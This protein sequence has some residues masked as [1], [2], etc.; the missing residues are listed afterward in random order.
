MDMNIISVQIPDNIAKTFPEKLELMNK[1]KLRHLEL[2]NQELSLEDISSS[3]LICTRNQ[4]IDEGGTVYLYKSSLSVTKR[5]SIRRLFRNAHLLEVSNVQLDFS[6]GS[7]DDVVY[8][9]DVAES[10][11][12]PLLI[13][14]QSDGPFQN[15]TQLEEFLKQHKNR[16]CGVFFNPLEFLRTGLHPFL[17]VFYAGRVKNHVSALRIN[18]GLYMSKEA[19]FPSRGN[20]E[21]KELISAMKVRSF[22]G[23]FSLTPYLPG[24]TSQDLMDMATWLRQTLKGVY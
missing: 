7:P 21:L 11:G 13:E 10:Y 20:G 17:D 6:S 23:F 16:D 1:L 14:N 18:D 22:D 15:S 8:C 4:L 24:C 19:V 3:E 5:E 12:I 2:S 9:F